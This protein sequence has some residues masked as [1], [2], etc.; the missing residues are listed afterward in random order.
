MEFKVLG[1]LTVRTDSHVLPIKGLRQ[2][3]ILAALLLESNRTVSVRRLVDVLWDG[4]PPRTATEQ[5]QNCTAQLRR[6]IDA[7]E[8]DVAI[9]T[10]RNG[11]LI[12]VDHGSVDAHVFENKRL[13]ARVRLEAGDVGGAVAVM[14]DALDLW[15]GRA[16]LEDV[17]TEPLLGAARRLDE[18]R[19]ATIGDYAGL[20]L[21]MGRY[22]AVTIELSECV[23]EYPYNERLH[24]QRARALHL[25]GRTAEALQT[26]GELRQRLGGELGVDVGS[27]IAAI[28]QDLLRATTPLAVG[29]GT[30]T[31]GPAPHD[32]HSH[33]QAAMAHLNAAFTLLASQA[34][35]RVD[36]GT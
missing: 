25:Q 36:H 16:A 29:S 33:V 13:Q 19:V 31:I 23:R 10:G 30:M 12:E 20:L 32:L 24:G 21:S 28:E 7:H 27:E 22:E 11:Y 6:V 15:H 26:L 4:T 2:R 8:S 3:R 9:R 5:V 34:A 14:R 17:V 1:P 18:L 35:L